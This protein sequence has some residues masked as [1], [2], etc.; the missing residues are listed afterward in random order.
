MS[1]IGE[2]HPLVAGTTPLAAFWSCVFVCVRLMEMFSYL[3]VFGSFQPFL[4]MILR[5]AASHS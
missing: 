1:L 4:P 5:S 3:F 2:A